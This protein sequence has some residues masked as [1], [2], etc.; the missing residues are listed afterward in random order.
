[1]FSFLLTSHP[2]R[3]ALKAPFPLNKLDIW[4]I[5]ETS[6]YVMLL[7]RSAAFVRSARSLLVQR[8]TEFFILVLVSCSNGCAVT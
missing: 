5:F 1:M 8:A 3:S 7:Y 2:D 6:Q 4:V